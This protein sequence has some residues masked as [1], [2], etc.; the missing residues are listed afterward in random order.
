MGAACADVGSWSGCIPTGTAEMVYVVLD[1]S[2]E[3]DFFAR[4][5]W[6]GADDDTDL[7]GWAAVRDGY[8]TSRAAFDTAAEAEWPV[9][10]TWSPAWRDAA[11]AAVGQT[12]ILGVGVR[13]R[14]HDGSV[15]VMLLS[16]GLQ[17]GDGAAILGAT[18]SQA[19]FDAAVG[20]TAAADWYADACQRD[21]AVGPTL[22]DFVLSAL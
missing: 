17:A 1:C 13:L 21:A 16:T 11:Y 7:T 4:L 2:E 6:R 15:P 14:Y 8:A 18:G 12:V 10:A 20:S 9:Y 3:G 22:R 19:A 5:G